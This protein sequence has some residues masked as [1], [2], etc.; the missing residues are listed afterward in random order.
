MYQS[1]KAAVPLVAPWPINIA[2]DK[3]E[4]HPAGEAQERTGHKYNHLPFWVKQNEP[5]NK[6]KLKQPVQLVD[7][8][9]SQLQ[10]TLHGRRKMQGGTCC[11][12]ISLTVE[13]D[14]ITIQGLCTLCNWPT[15]SLCLNYNSTI[16]GQL[17]V[18]WG[19]GDVSSSAVTFVQGGETMQTDGPNLK[20]LERDDSQRLK[21]RFKT[22][23]EVSGCWVSDY[24][25]EEERLFQRSLNGMCPLKS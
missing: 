17:R 16:V 14:R 24:S 19:E 11:S 7:T 3:V 13:R 23:W 12:V 4:R 6:I 8:H 9:S 25:C 5:K 22:G 20:G 2:Q 15:I 10:I 18:W 21:A 1:D